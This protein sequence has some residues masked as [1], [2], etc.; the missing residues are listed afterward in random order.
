MKKSFLII[1]DEILEIPISPAAILREIE[2]FAKKNNETIIFREKVSPITFEM[3][4]RLYKVSI[5]F[6]RST[7]VLSCKEI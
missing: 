2:R 1:P 6:S 4:D 3:D 5:N 7:P